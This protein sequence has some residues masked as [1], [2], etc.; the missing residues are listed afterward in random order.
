MSFKLQNLNVIRIVET[1]AQKQ[2]LIAQGFKDITPK[3]APQQ[4]PQQT[5]S[6]PP[7]ATKK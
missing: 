5:P 2:R 7:K 3:Q 1:E 6:A 4:A